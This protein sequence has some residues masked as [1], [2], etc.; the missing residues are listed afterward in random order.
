[1]AAAKRGSPAEHVRHC[2]CVARGF[3]AAVPTAAVP[4]VHHRLVFTLCAVAAVHQAHQG[5]TAG[6]RVDQ[7]SGQ[8]GEGRQAGS[9]A[10]RGS[11]SQP[12]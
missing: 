12:W 7:G 8:L 9:R 3:A 1:M 4:R 2:R 6:D 10:A 11:G 5:C